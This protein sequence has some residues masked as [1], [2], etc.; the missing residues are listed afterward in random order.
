MTPG[1][2]LGLGS[3]GAIGM[4]SSSNWSLTLAVLLGSSTCSANSSSSLSYFSSLVF[5]FF[6]FAAYGLTIFKNTNPTIG[7]QNKV[8]ESRR[9][10]CDT[11]LRNSV[12]RRKRNTEEPK[13]LKRNKREYRGQGFR[14]EDTLTSAHCG[15]EHYL[16]TFTSNLCTQSLM[17][18]YVF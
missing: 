3:V 4:P 17:D 13:M 11:R 8:E 6:P 7:L 10:A 1:P 15:T 5:R 2:F 12:V 18:T 14:V 16:Y 9:R